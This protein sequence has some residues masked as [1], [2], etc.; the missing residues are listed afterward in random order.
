MA[1]LAKRPTPGFG[2]DHGLT[3]CEFEPHIGLHTD[4]AE[5]AWDSLSPS[6]SLFASPLL[7]LSVS[8]KMN[9]LKIIIKKNINVTV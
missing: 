9:K 3:F 7:G 6:L 4:R 2:S 1:Q 8:L 5:P